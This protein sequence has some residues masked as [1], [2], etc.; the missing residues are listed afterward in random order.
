MSSGPS[1]MRSPARRLVRRAV[2]AIASAGLLVA[3]LMAITLVGLTL[4]ERHL[5]PPPM[6]ETEKLSTV[7]LD[8][9]DRLLRAFTT[10]DG[11]WRLPATV[12]DVDPRYLK[13]LLAFE[14]RRFYEHGGIDLRALARAGAQ[15][16]SNLR[17][18][19]GGST[20]TM[21]VARLIDDGE[22]HSFTAKLRQ[23]VRARQIE[24]RLGKRQILDLYL[25][26]A[27]FGGNIE[28]VRAA[29]LAWFGKEP[30]RLTPGEAA[31]LVAL[32]QSPE[33]RR[34]DRFADNARRARDRVLDRA[35]TAGIISSAEAR[36]AREERVPTARRAFPKLA[37]HLADA[38]VKA[39][40]DQRIH[41]TTLD[42]AAQA[43]L[44]AL[45]S[46][47]ARML[48]TGL[49]VALIA[50]EHASGRVVARV[51]SADYLD[52]ARNGA[53]DMVS[54]VRSPGSTL[55]PLIYALGFELGLAHPEMLIE[56]RLTRFGAYAPKNFD[57][58]FHGTVTVA[59]ALARSLNVP[60]VKMLAAVGP[61]RLA[62]RL[63]RAGIAT[64][65][66]PGA[67]PS[68]A[69]A[70]GGIGMRLEDLAALYA[71][72]ARGG[73]PVVVTHS[74]EGAPIAV[75]APAAT[76]A[77]K[78]RPRRLIGEVAAFYVTDI[79][80]NAP[81][82]PAAKSGRIAFKTGTS[83]GYR[84]A[85]AVGYDGRHTI[86]VW[87]GRADA[88]PVPGL[89]GRTAA[90]PI[91]FDAFQRLT[92]DRTPF[93]TAPTGVLKVASGEALPP[94]LKRFETAMGE[95]APGPFLEPAVAIAFPPD[96]SE[97]EVEG[98]DTPLVLK[99][100]GGALPLTWL[101]DG[102]PIGATANTREL[103]WQ[104]QGEGFVRLSVI[105][106]K[107]RVDRVTVRLRQP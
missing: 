2:L 19:S 62:G 28:G 65:L 80:R 59:E 27:P 102:A 46:E 34:P 16:A 85:L 54:A 90:A 37:P 77:A 57:E 5:G 81:P 60:A 79:L 25:R 92:P 106:A 73:L 104:P 4:A 31:L 12:D 94:P 23:L 3:G 6:A 41:R 93:P 44:E 68:L 78:P 87:V 22:A 72:I 17:I 66:A 51:G 15:L 98:R 99:A 61:G 100:D 14:D 101:A 97:V 64:E 69:V 45:A 63:A 26:L 36:H 10:A 86:A 50:V 53:I 38:E 83:Y 13:M 71:A 67:I 103:A 48:G 55:K 11:R 49:S 70:L 33:R 88:A 9:S 24:R 29:S 91:L 42:A 58:E 8:R 32:P 20:L 76:T 40:P 84:D 21:Q 47:H 74:R 105:D 43:G 35:A 30:K 7:M 95:T 56:D 18:V 39:R 96:R 89:M 107:G 75:D 82:P 1:T 52:D